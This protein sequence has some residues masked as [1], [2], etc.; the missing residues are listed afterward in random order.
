MKKTQLKDALRNIRKQWVSWL[1]IA[2]IAML[3]VTAYLGVRF[4]AQAIRENG[5]A[6]YNE[7]AFRDIEV[8]STMLLTDGDLAAIRGLSGVRDVQG[9]RRTS[10]SAYFGEASVSADIVSLTDR[11]NVPRILEGALPQA[12]GQCA[13]EAEVAEALGLQ[14]GDVIA[15]RDPRGGNAQYLLYET[16]TVTGIVQHPEHSATDI[17]LPGNRDVIVPADAFDSAALDGGYMSAQ[18]LLDGTADADRFSKEYRAAVDA[19]IERIE[20]LSQERAPL[21][22]TDVRVRAQDEIDEGKTELAQAEAEL[23]DA[24]GRLDDAQAQLADNQKK[25]EDAEK[26]L[27]DS[28]RELEDGKIEL[29]DA[30]NVLEDVRVQLEDAGKELAAGKAVLDE[31]SAELADAKR[32]LDAAARELADGKAELDENGALLEQA[33]RELEKAA[34]ELADGEKQ[35]ADGEKQLADAKRELESGK[36]QL[37]DAKRQLDEG[38]ARLEDGARQLDDAQAQLAEARA[39]LSDAEEQLRSSYI[40]I[41]KQK[42]NIRASIRETMREAL[43]MAGVPE[44]AAAEA[45]ASIAWAVPNDYPDITDPNLRA[46]YI[47]ITQ[48]IGFELTQIDLPEIRMADARELFD[49]ALGRLQAMGVDTAPVEANAQ[50]IRERLEEKLAEFEKLKDDYNTSVELLGEWDSGH[51][52]YLAGREEYLEGLAQYE[53]GERDYLEGRMQLADGQKAYDEG[54][55]EYE[56]GLAAYEAGLAEFTSKKQLYED[57]VRQY[58]EGKARYEDGLAKYEDGLKAYEAGLAQYKDGEAQYYAG[59][60][61]IDAAAAQYDASAAQLESAKKE[62]EQG[63]ADYESAC[64]QY[65]DGLAQYEDGLAEFEEGKRRLEEGRQTLEEKEEEYARGLAAYEDGEAQ[66][67]SAQEELDTMDPA[68]WIVLGPEGNGGYSLACGNAENIRGMGVTFVLIFL[69]VGAQVIYATV[70][71]IVDEQRRLV[72]T[73]KAL[74]F[75]NR[76][77]MFKYLCFG[78]SAALIGGAFGFILGYF[79]IQPIFTASYGSSYV[80]APLK[81]AF[82][83]TDTAVVLAGGAVLAALTVFAACRELLRSAATKLM[84]ERTPSVRMKKGG[85]KK[86]LSLYWRLALLNMLS[87]KK[88]VAVTVAS[89]AGCCTILVAGFSIRSGILGALDKQFDAVGVWDIR[90]EYDPSVSGVTQAQIEAILR[91]AGAEWTQLRID[92]VPIGANGK[93]DSRELL[94]GTLKELDRYYARLEPGSGEAMPLS[95]EGVFVTLRTAEIYDLQPGSE[96]I[97]Y[98]AAMKP[99]PAKVA[100]VFDCY[101]GREMILS[102]AAYARIFGR[103]PEKNAFLILLR[104]AD[105]QTLCAQLRKIPGVGTVTDNAELRSTYQEFVGVLDVVAVVLT[106]MAGVMA[107]FILLN[108]ANMYINQKKREMT[109]MRV[110]GFTVKEVRR[111]VAG[112]AVVS[113]VLGIALGLVLGSLLYRRL[114]ALAENGVMHFLRGVQWSSWLYAALITL[115]FSVSIYSLALRKIKYLKLTDAAEG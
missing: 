18:V 86:A 94:C 65:E 108:L 44:E 61:Q 79:G 97:L 87:D 88:R 84:Q 98:D 73:T 48:Q 100:G 26:T 64:A 9:V 19:A 7:T 21:R 60:A 52:Q 114:I 76:E 8:L 28:M 47:Q 20:A 105:A 99:Y 45:V 43:C 68:R 71:R 78:V 107:L 66:L 1:S 4:S 25:L 50:M 95:D 29:S 83:L 106:V 90:A 3:A 33:K 113:T 112:E 30:W 85:R 62:Y 17:M 115:L 77:I 23:S 11:V 70:G 101:I 92:Q 55:A 42:E 58:R 93:M 16:F 59:K 36:A 10:G 109:V 82:N 37:D 31:K 41:E 110:N 80:Y 27:S 91:S 57:G 69:L 24:R 32:T 6:F 39:Q 96:M 81:P 12:E 51:E 40:E 102:E 34:Q 13:V 54:L 75:Y 49:L 104:G 22:D 56:K 5:S 35:L 67:R 38:Y 2:V 103:E 63:L 72:G 74:G 14:V 89:I 111:Y 53:E 46:V 15:L